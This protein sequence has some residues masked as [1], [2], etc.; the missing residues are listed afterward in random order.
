MVKDRDAME[1]VKTQC[2]AEE[3]KSFML[4][5]ACQEGVTLVVIRNL[6]FDNKIDKTLRRNSALGRPEKQANNDVHA[7]YTAKTLSIAF[8]F[9]YI[10]HEKVR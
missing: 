4:A 9:H 3:N 1:F 8:R 2:G 7:E 5:I 6:P 10:S